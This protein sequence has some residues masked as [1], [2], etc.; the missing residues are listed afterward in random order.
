MLL[1]HPIH[2]NI[3]IIIK[4][5][6]VFKE[7]S[8]LMDNLAF[9]ILSYI[10]MTSTQIPVQKRIFE[11]VVLQKIV[12]GKTTRN[13]DD[14]QIAS[15]APPPFCYQIHFIFGTIFIRFLPSLDNIE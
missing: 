7:K 2:N 1:H 6:R 11:L 12:F 10:S 14:I 5:K 3:I 15:A 9:H 13:K 4:V 8:Q